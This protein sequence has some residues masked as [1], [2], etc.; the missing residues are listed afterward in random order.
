VNKDKT[1]CN[2]YWGNTNNSYKGRIIQCN[3]L[4]TEVNGKKNRSK[5][6]HWCTS[7]PMRKPISIFHLP[8]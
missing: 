6:M 4:H 2:C 3:K 8:I 1:C 7:P 5:C